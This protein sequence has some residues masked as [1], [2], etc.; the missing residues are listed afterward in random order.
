MSGIAIHARL[1]AKSSREDDLEAW[2]Q[3]IVERI[4]AGDPGTTAFGFYKDAASGGYVCIEQYRDADSVVAHFGNVAD[5]LQKLGDLVE[6]GDEPVEVCGNLSPEIREHY[7][8]WNP[9]FLTPVAAL[10]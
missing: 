9:R 4:R 6:P 7:I 2:M 5:L 3:E 10:S 1:K 8:P